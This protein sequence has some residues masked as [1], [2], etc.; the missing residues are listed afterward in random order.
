MFFAV[1]EHGERSRELILVTPSV[2]GDLVGVA[3]RGSDV[4]QSTQNPS[5]PLGL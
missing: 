2:L 1:G 5:G 3:Q 4:F